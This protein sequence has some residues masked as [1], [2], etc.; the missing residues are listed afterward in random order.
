MDIEYVANY[1][2]HH[3]YLYLDTNLFLNQCYQFVVLHVGKSLE[4]SGINIHNTVKIQI[5]RMH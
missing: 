4:I 5:K 2:Q 3:I 1:H